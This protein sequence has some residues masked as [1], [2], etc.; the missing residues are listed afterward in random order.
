MQIRKASVERT[1]LVGPKWTFGQIPKAITTR[2]CES[3]LLNT[4]IINIAVSD[5]SEAL[6]LE[7]SGA[8]GGTANGDPSFPLKKK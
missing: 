8:P 2:R 7:T 5:T 4:V 1:S 3:E 6:Y